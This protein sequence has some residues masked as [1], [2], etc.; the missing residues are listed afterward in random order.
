MKLLYTLPFFVLALT[1]CSGPAAQNEFVTNIMPLCG[2]SYAGAVVST[3]AVDEDWRNK[4]II[5]GPIVCS[6]ADIRM[7]LAVGEN[8]SRT[9]VLIPQKRTLTL[10]HDHRHNDGTPDAV[11]WYGGTT[12]TDGSAK[13]QEFPVDD[14][15]IVLFTKEGLSASVVNTWA[16][17]IEPG[18]TFTYEL[19]RPTTP[20]QAAAGEPGR[21]FRIEFDISKPL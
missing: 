19:S 14:F 5:I 6:V 21:L 12:R 16:M 10:K 18:E 20:K 1:A 3:D 2:H 15:S 9:W 4:K 11:S 13:R 17:E 8:T 7:P